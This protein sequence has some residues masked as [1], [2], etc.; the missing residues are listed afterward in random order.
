VNPS[1]AIALSIVVVED[2]DTCGGF[3][4]NNDSRGEVKKEFVRIITQ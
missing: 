2:G 4:R 1:P 3:L